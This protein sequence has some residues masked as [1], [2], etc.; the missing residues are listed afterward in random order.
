MGMV[1]KHSSWNLVITA[2]GFVLGAVNVLLLATTYLNDN[3]YG[4]WG[5]VLSTSFLIFPL[6]SFGIHNTIVK[7]YSSYKTK[8]ERDNFLSQMLLWPLVALTFIIGLI[9]IYQTDLRLFISSRNQISG[10][11]LW[12]IVLVAVFQAYFEIWYSW[13]KVHYKT[14][15]GNFLKEVFYRAAATVML[16]LVALDIITQTQF[17]YSLVLI[18]FLRMLLMAIVALR[19]Y[20]PVFE[21]KK[22][23]A[24]RELVYYSVLMIIAGSV[25]TALLDL[26]KTMINQYIDIANIA[27]YNVPVFMA[28]VVAIP[29]RGMAQII[30]PLTAR[31]FNGNQ[32]DEVENLYKRSSLNLTIIA[33]LLLLLVLC[34]ASQFYLFLPPEFAVA[35][36]VLFFICI[37]KFTENVL[38]SNNAILYSTNLYQVTLWLGLALA[39]VAWLLNMWLIPLYGLTG[40]AIATCVAYVCYAFA[41]AVYVKIKL[42][43][44]PWTRETTVVLLVVVVLLVAFYFWDFP[45]DKYTNI[46]LKSTLISLLYIA[47]VYRLKLSSEINDL[48]HKG[49]EKI[50]RRP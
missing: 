49:I 50:K 2:I 46:L 45:F 48:V 35:L 24:V 6:M 44:H 39:V 36:P 41:K 43:M 47:S 5:Y 20:T 10:D 40:A 9:Y 4:L 27:Y 19:V 17:I 1:I 37:V 23:V 12:A 28:T 18:Y 15:G 29:S 33:G 14:I 21:I 25:A 32:L 3:Y 30:H 34:N 31:F 8:E 7:F 26:D 22:L 38:G 13:T 16:C 11:Y 42:N